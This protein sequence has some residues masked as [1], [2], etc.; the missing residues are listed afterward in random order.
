MWRNY[1]LLLAFV[2][3]SVSPAAADL[4]DVT[5]G[6]GANGSGV[7][8]ARCATCPSGNDVESLSFG[9]T[10]SMNDNFTSSSGTVTAADRVTMS[11]SVQQ[12][13]DVS[14]ASFSVDLET[15]VTLDAIGAEWGASAD[16]ANSYFLNFTLTTESEMHLS[17]PLNVGNS[18]TQDQCYLRS[19]DFNTS[20]PLPCFDDGSFDQSFTLGPGTYFLSLADQLITDSFFEGNNVITDHLVLTADFTPIPE[21][22]WGVFLLA[23]LL[24]VVSG[25]ASLRRH[26]RA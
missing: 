7:I 20:I 9:G 17:E 18:S 3:L 4:V 12:I 24:V 11:G 13:T 25:Y 6:G 26:G 10:N 19:A 23:S 1:S 2:S 16:I 15:L 14:P 21:P 8:I 5:F 22:G